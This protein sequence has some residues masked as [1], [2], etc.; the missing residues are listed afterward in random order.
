VSNKLALWIATP[1]TTSY[2]EFHPARVL[3]LLENGP[4]RLR[5]NSDIRTEGMAPERLDVEEEDDRQ[6]RLREYSHISTVHL[7]Y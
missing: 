7:K 5:T 3:G 6:R 1:L 2:T 4:N